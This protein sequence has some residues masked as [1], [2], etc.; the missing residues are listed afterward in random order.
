MNAWLDWGIPVIAWLQ[1][2]GE[3]LVQPMKLFTFLGTEQFF[4]LVMPAVLW[5]ID[6]GLGYRLA[7]ILLMSDGLNGTLKLAFGWPRPYWVTSQVRAWSTETSFG[8]P[9]GHAQN[10]LAL[11]GR[12]AASI[13][14]R[15]AAIFFGLL[16]LLISLSRLYLGVHW[17]SDMLAGWVVGGLLLWAFLGLDQPVRQW[18]ARLSVGGRVLVA[19][20]LSLAILALQLLVYWLTAG[21]P[22]PPEWAQMAAAAAPGSEPINPRNLEGMFTSAG[23]L[24]GIGVGGALLFAWGQFDAGGP[25]WK[26]A[27]RY[28]IGLV[29]VVALWMGL[30]AIFPSGTSALALALRYLRY[31]VIGL[32][33]VYLGPRVFVWLRLA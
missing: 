1:G 23:L 13:R 30:D 26:R 25:W 8:L 33:A 21:R 22:I 3:W 9:S 19:F 24:L 14:R 7:L 11:W 4:M 18:L 10:A 32:W 5:C 29:G 31:S 2:L 17:P 16:I 27:G 6:V 28:A 12:L 15:W 20:G